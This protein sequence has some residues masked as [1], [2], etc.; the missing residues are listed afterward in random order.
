MQTDVSRPGLHVNISR[1]VSKAQL[2]SG[3]LGSPFKGSRA[4]NLSMR[5][6]ASFNTLPHQISGYLPQKNL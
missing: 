2:G 4:S 1:N 6:D 3:D 5:N